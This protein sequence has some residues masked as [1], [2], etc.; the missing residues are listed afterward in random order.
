[1]L[2]LLKKKLFFSFFFFTIFIV[3][4]QSPVTINLTEKD[5]LPDIEF[6][7]IIEDKKGFIWLAADKGLYRYNG[8]T[9]QNYTHKKKRGLSVFNLTEDDK[10]RIWCANI[11]GQIFY[12]ENNVLKLFKDISGIMNTILPEFEIHEE[13]I[14]VFSNQGVYKIDFET[15]KIQTLPFNQEEPKNVAL[16]SNYFFQERNLSTLTENNEIVVLLTKEEIYEESIN[17]WR[18]E[19]I[20]STV[21]ENEILFLYVP[22]F[23]QNNFK[24]YNK[25]TKKTSLITSPEALKATP[26]INV[27]RINNQL[28]FSTKKGVHVYD[29]NNGF[30][31]IKSYLKDYTISKVL[32]DGDNNYWFT[33]LN[34]GVILMPNIAVEAYPIEIEAKNIS[35]LAKYDDETIFYGTVN[36]YFGVYNLNTKFNK[37]YELDADERIFSIAY[38]SKNNEAYISQANK[39]YIFSFKE[40]VFRQSTE[41]PNAKDIAIL[42][43]NDLLFTSYFGAATLN[44]NPKSK[45]KIISSKRGYTCFY[46]TI[47]QNSYVA[48]ADNLVAYDSLFNLTTIKNGE[49]PIFATSITETKDSI[50]WVST[51]KEGIYGIKDNKVITNFNTKNGLVSNQITK[52]K[53]DGN[54]IWIVSDK[55]IQLF[56]TTTRQFKTLTKQDAIPSFKIS[57]ISIFKDKTV[58]SSNEG[59]FSIK[60]EGFYKENRKP[61]FDFVAISINEKDTVLNDYYKLPYHKNRTQLLFNTNGFQ[62]NKYIQYEYRLLE[63]SQH[64]TLLP[65]EINSLQFNALSEG[66]NTIEVRALNILK[67]IK[68]A[69]KKVVFFIETPYWKTWWFYTFIFITTATIIYLILRKQ[70]QLKE[71]E[72][73]KALDKALLANQVIALRL[74]N[75]RSQM[76]PH[77]IFNALNSIQDYIIMNQ[78]NEASDYLGQFADLIRRYLGFSNSGKLSIVEEVETLKIYLKLEALRFED[79]F[80]YHISLAHELNNMNISIPTMMVQPYVENAIRHGLLHKNGYRKLVVSFLKGENETIIC[81]IEDNGIGRKKGIEIRKKQFK[82]HKSF[83]ETATKERL[84]LFNF[85]ERRKAGVEIIDL[86]DNDT[87]IGTKVV[88]KIPILD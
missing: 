81:I 18:K 40:N 3:C 78:K 44:T 5:G 6:Y 61:E 80:N 38:G 62:S 16:K 43:N 60:N 15:K 72:K 48:F 4:G 68:S 11:T 32:K 20:V 74:Q 29:F 76:N 46:S 17:Y 79:N 14:L 66:K 82:H 2:L 86:Y 45:R 26:I 30:K 25:E 50:L 27:Q 63:E 53:S 52:I 85:V 36:G 9:F 24:L 37:T 58:F 88:V 10:G 67:D 41:F 33:T 39:S 84:D 23:F 51:F 47:S 65:Q 1:M 83:A 21:N 12:V 34:S 54:N 31:H 75:L 56:N 57:G 73:N 49:T 13:Y 69:T 8:K 70:Y 59:I 19:A 42:G 22:S 64:W 35:A 87:P 7:D 28:W 77:F 55:A 71:N